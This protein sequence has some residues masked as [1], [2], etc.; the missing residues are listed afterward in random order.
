MV[1]VREP[2]WEQLPGGGWRMLQQ[3]TP[4]E[5]SKLAYAARVVMKAELEI[6]E[7]RAEQ[8]WEEEEWTKELAERHTQEEERAM[9][10]VQ[11]RGMSFCCAR[12]HS[13]RTT[14]AR[15]IPRIASRF[16]GASASG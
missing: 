4:E 11:T 2:I 14:R 1:L 15:S 13:L 7:H 8:K 3:L 6:A 12:R 5:S 16:T 10:S 9:R